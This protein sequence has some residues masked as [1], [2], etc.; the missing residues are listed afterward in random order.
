MYSGLPP[1]VGVQHKCHTYSFYWESRIFP[2]SSAPASSATSPE[3]PPGRAAPRL[4][5]PTSQVAQGPPQHHSAGRIPRAAL[6]MPGPLR[7]SALLQLRTR[8]QHKPPARVA[9]P[10]PASSVRRHRQFRPQAALSPSSSQ[11]IKNTSLL[12][13]PASHRHPHIFYRFWQ[14]V[15]APMCRIIEGFQSGRRSSLKERPSRCST[16]HAPHFYQ[17]TWGNTE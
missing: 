10:P 13:P 16:G 5:E 11:A 3:P 14:F 12:L 15:L 2:V 8:R 6:T 17:E 4:R 1:S 7:V 9:A